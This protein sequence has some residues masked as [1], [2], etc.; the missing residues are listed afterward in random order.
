MAALPKR[1]RFTVVEY[2]QMA[3]AGILNEDDRVE[4]IKGEIIQMPP[5]GVGHASVVNRLNHLFLHAFGDAVTVT[6]QNPLRIS[7][8]SEPVPDLL[9][10]KP[11]SDFY[12]ERHPMP[13]DVLLL[14]EVSDTTLRYDR[15]EKLPLY[16]KASVPE[17]WIVD[18][19]ADLVH[20][21]SRPLGDTYRYEFAWRRGDQHAPTAFPEIKLAV[22]DILGEPSP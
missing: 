8:R 17:V 12:G 9:L 22:D 1:R 11:R 19:K 21:Y 13:E 2:Y 5:I 18:L 15:D 6:V 16:A 20:T 10:L 3:D 14:V 4:L 7:G